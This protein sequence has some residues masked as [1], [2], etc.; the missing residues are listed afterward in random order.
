MYIIET[1]LCNLIVN[2]FNVYI[3]IPHRHT[4]N[5]SVTSRDL[6]VGTFDLHVTSHI[7][8][9]HVNLHYFINLHLHYCNIHSTYILSL[10]IYYCRL[11]FHIEF[12]SKQKLSSHICAF[13]RKCPYS[14]GLS[15]GF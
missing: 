9:R 2:F 6:R 7:S 5:H 15:W 14:H 1:Y 13:F 10:H 12:G 11:A 3:N 4:E 8:I